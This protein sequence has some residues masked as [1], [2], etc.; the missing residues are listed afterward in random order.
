[1]DETV[2][3]EIVAR[4][5]I[6]V[7]HMNDLFGVGTPYKLKDGRYARKITV[8]KESLILLMLQYSSTLEVNEPIEIRKE[9]LEKIS[10]IYNIYSK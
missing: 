10:N 2:T 3:V 9:I 6:G 7:L 4:E 5:E 8:G 1:M